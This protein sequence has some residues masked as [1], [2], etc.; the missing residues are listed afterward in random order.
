MESV[1][2]VDIPD[3]TVNMAHC[4]WVIEK[5]KELKA[6]LSHQSVKMISANKIRAMADID[7]MMDSLN[8][9]KLY[10]SDVSK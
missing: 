2:A 10:I 3:Y 8:E 9:L 6:L 1:K 5:A 4:D 7:T